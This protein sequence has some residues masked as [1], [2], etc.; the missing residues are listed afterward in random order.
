MQGSL[1]HPDDGVPRVRSGLPESK[2]ENP[3]GHGGDHEVMKSSNP[4][5]YCA[6]I[7][8]R[9][10][11]YDQQWAKWIHSQLE[12]YRFPRRL[13]KQVGLS[14]L[15]RVFRDVDELPANGCLSG[16]IEAALRASESLVVIC[17]PQ[18][19][20][21]EWVAAEVEYFI[22][23]GRRHQ[24][25]V[26]MIAGD[27]QQSF[28]AALLRSLAD[29]PDE[30]GALDRDARSSLEP[31][32]ADARDVGFGLRSAMARKDVL[33]RVVAAI[34]RLGYDDLRRR[35]AER[36]ARRRM[37]WLCV[38]SLIMLVVSGLGLQSYRAMMVA[39]DRLEQ[40]R[41]EA[42]V[43]HLARAA[44]CWDTGKVELA[45]AE[46]ALAAQY[47][48][49]SDFVFS[50][51]DRRNVRPSM[52]IATGS[53]VLR[54]GVGRAGTRLLVMNEGK[55]EHWDLQN[56]PLLRWRLF[57]E[58]FHFAG[59]AAA[60]D[61]F[62]AAER[63]FW[64][65]PQ[66]ARFALES[67]E[68]A[69]GIP[70][71]PAELRLEL[72]EDRTPLA[73]PADI[74]CSRDG[75]VV[76]ISANGRSRVIRRV[77]GEYRLALLAESAGVC[78][79][80]PRGDLVAAEC[81]DNRVRLYRAD[82]LSIAWASEELDA[83]PGHRRVLRFSQDGALL[84]VGQATEV[85]IIDCKK[86]SSRQRIPV[87]DDPTSLAFDSVSTKLAIGLRSGA[88]VVDSLIGKRATSR[89]S[90]HEGAVT[91]LEFDFQDT[92]ISGGIDGRV[93]FWS[94]EIVEGSA[95]AQY[96]EGF[97]ARRGWAWT[98]S[99]NHWASPLWSV[100]F[101]GVTGLVELENWVTKERAESPIRYLEEPLLASSLSGD[102]WI[103]L[104]PSQLTLWNP[105]QNITRSRDLRGNQDP[106][107]VR[108]LQCS[109]DGARILILSKTKVTES[110]RLET[111][112]SDGSEGVAGARWEPPSGWDLLDASMDP[113]GAQLAVL[114]NRK[115]VSQDVYRIVI[116]EFLPS[117]P[118]V[119]AHA[120]F[121]H[122]LQV[123]SPVA[124][125]AYEK[126]FNF[127]GLRLC[128][129]M[130]G[131]SVFCWNREIVLEVPTTAAPVRTLR[132]K[133]GEDVVAIAVDPSGS[134]VAIG[135]EN[136]VEMLDRASSR[137]VLRA[138]YAGGCR[139]MSFDSSGESCVVV[140]WP[141]ALVI[142]AS[143]RVRVR[144]A[145][146][147]RHAMATPPVAVQW[148]VRTVEDR[149][150]LLETA[151]FEV[152]ID[153]CLQALRSSDSLEPCAV[154]RWV[155][156]ACR[157]TKIVKDREYFAAQVRQLRI[158]LVLSGRKLA[159]AGAQPDPF[160]LYLAAAA[161]WWGGDEDEARRLAAE[162]VACA[163]DSVEVSLC[164][165][166]NGQ[167]R[168][169]GTMSRDELSENLERML[170]STPVF[171]LPEKGP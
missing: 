38:A 102:W 76:A 37:A 161:M 171:A 32:A 121:D 106:A 104:A 70:G 34:A 91:A 145:A 149:F 39:N 23:L 147:N 56:G 67:G 4:P 154:A 125:D 148:S 97:G 63:G 62:L 54:L 79:V 1:S 52:E 24:I 60:E 15:G 152:I 134:Y 107:N 55:L 30:L 168:R 165:I 35:D 155:L 45:E 109:N 80:S 59:L 131:G 65:D 5:R 84:A 123:K 71:I 90:A 108:K 132:S 47:K 41:H 83:R 157:V 21:S 99:L 18:T 69:G 129:P 26:L 42:Y 3:Q 111:G 72:R 74:Q 128:F 164:L 6:F 96:I 9:H 43:T 50:A 16:Q 66:V 139:S 48:T 115:D 98:G 82:N 40:V 170:E 150:P 140:C 93:T 61:E 153:E 88:I 143:E 169:L 94:R 44:E 163:A 36:A 138:S 13:R 159:L 167:T 95:L 85:V 81:L 64:G 136:S 58:Q 135:L 151:H 137:V 118:A 46:M 25:I 89:L 53:A 7:S 87:A 113:D 77:N 124:R 119:R 158:A 100:S 105:R 10:L 126:A 27:P 11:P 114:L 166:E 28:P 122:E 8:Y 12:S 116:H 57:P 130:Q 49:R 2:T 75:A 29:E 78:A 33:L 92:L 51:I 20:A 162:A 141:G 14:K 160:L 133:D 19:P 112:F 73:G 144:V 17:S 110:A 86:R 146:L 142:S 156:A 127:G 22:R 117:N 31:L 120:V 68:A 103:V 101:S